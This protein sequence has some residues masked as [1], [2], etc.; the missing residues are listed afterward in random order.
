MYGSAANA[1]SQFD[2]IHGMED[3]NFQLVGENISFFSFE[4]VN[5]WKNIHFKQ[6][7]LRGQQIESRITGGLLEAHPAQSTTQ[8]PR[9]SAAVPQAAAEGS[10]RKLNLK[11]GTRKFQIREEGDYSKIFERTL[12]YIKPVHNKFRILE[13]PG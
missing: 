12:I 2:Y 11:N 8:L 13:R 5:F 6:R 10:G 3:N 9:S 7:L 1:G 4:K